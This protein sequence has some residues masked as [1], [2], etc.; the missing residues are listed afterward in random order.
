GANTYTGGTTIGSGKLQIGDGG[1]KGSIIGDVA[2]DGTLIF[3]RSNNVTFN[4]AVDG[5]GS[6]IQAGKGVLTLTGTN[7]YTGG[8]AINSGTL[9]IGDGGSNGSIAGDITNKGSL[10]FD[11]SDDAIFRGVISGKGS[12][13]QAGP[14]ALILT[15]ANTYTGGTIIS[16]GRLQVGDNATRGSIAGDVIDNGSLVFDRRDKVVYT[17]SISG[18][19]QLMAATGP[20]VLDGNS[21]GFAGH[22]IVAGSA[23]IVGS[24]PDV[25]AV[26]GG[27]VHVND[28]VQ[29]GGYGSGGDVTVAADGVLAPGSST[30]FGTAGTFG[31][32]TVNGDLMMEKGSLLH[33]NLGASAA[34]SGKPGKGDSVKV[35]GNLV[36]DGAGL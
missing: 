35:N 10:I 31:T 27:A 2:D 20:L 36:L 21:S 25:D 16:A 9:R 17:G 34:A 18:N 11:R 15:G 7:T 30:L 14:G 13:T 24:T 5:T 29:L 1:K 28:G 3:N 22:T 6:L 4:G 23:L 33:L 12:V 8:T 19:G 26:L 32:L